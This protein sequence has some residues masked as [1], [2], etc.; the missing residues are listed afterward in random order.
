MI[1][2]IP[3]ILEKNFDDLQ[4]R[5][6]QVQDKVR[7]VEIDVLDSTLYPN[8]T[9]NSHWEALVRWSE[10]FN[11]AAHIMCSDPVKY[12]EPLVKAGFKRLIADVEGETVRDFIMQS[13]AHEVEVGIA[14][15]GAA[16]LELVEPYLGEIDTVLIMTINSGVSGSPFLPETLPKIKKIHENYPHLP[17]EVDGGINKETAPLVIDNGA[18][19]LVSTSYLFW[20]NPDRIAQAIEDLKS[21]NP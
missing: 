4:K 1:E 7:W 11:L 3:G 12:V 2:V 8:D 16:P 5:L 20:K 6:I 18:T 15:D 9:Y 14:L 19:R 10:H 13:R 17:I 21:G